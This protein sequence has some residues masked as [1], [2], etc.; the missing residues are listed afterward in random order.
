LNKKT[1][2]NE[3]F[4]KSK[5]TRDLQEAGVLYKGGRKGKKSMSLKMSETNWVFKKR[6]RIIKAYF[7]YLFLIYNF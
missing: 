7:D 1:T 2:K 5:D 4:V 6:R 3:A